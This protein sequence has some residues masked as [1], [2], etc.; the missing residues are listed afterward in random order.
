VTCRGRPEAGFSQGGR[1]T[2]HINRYIQAMPSIRGMSEAEEQILT[3]GAPVAVSHAITARA[4]DAPAF[5]CFAA[6][7]V[8]IFS[9]REI[10][11]VSS[12][13]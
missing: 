1:W 8:V 6:V 3:R 5:R 12:G 9:L 4:G 2:R 13:K 7:S 11:A 10:F